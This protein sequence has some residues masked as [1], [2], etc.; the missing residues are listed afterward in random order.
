M[1]QK[2]TGFIFVLVLVVNQRL[3]WTKRTKQPPKL[4]R[5]GLDI[6]NA[7]GGSPCKNFRK[8][9]LGNLLNLIN[10]LSVRNDHL[11]KKNGEGF[12][13]SPAGNA[14]VWG[15]S[16]QR[17][18]SID[19]VWKKTQDMV[20]I[21]QHPNIPISPIS[22]ISDVSK[23]R[24]LNFPISQFSIIS[25]LQYFNISISQYLNISIFQYLNILIYQYFNISIFQ[26]LNISI[27]QYFN[28]SIFQYFN[29]L[30]F[31]QSNILI[32]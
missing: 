16:E 17:Y 4:E 1:D 22:P 23:F 21:F 15:C 25:I 7:S 14:W 30:I 13:P 19:Y 28:I 27:S 2:S 6:I 26:Y 9:S 12:R 31:Q 3:T 32:F 24:Y 10:P 18:E 8:G 11:P 20:L 29:I 5:V